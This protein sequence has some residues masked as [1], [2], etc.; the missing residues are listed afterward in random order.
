MLYLFEQEVVV[1]NG[2][3]FPKSFV[4]ESELFRA[5]LLAWFVVS[6]FTDVEEVE[7]DNVV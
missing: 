6:V 4:L 1:R 5:L 7:K 3:A 2:C